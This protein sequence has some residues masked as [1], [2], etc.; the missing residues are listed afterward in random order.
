MRLTRLPYNLPARLSAQQSARISNLRRELVRAQGDDGSWTCPSALETLVTTCQAVLALCVLGDARDEERVNRAVR[1]LARPEVMNQE[2]AYWSAAVFNCVD[3]W[4]EE[5]DETFRRCEE[6]AVVGLKHHKDS[7]LFE[8]VCEQAKLLGKPS[9]FLDAHLGTIVSEIDEAEKRSQLNA[10]V[11]SYKYLVLCMAGGGS[12]D[13]TSAVLASLLARAFVTELEASWPG[14]IAS[15]AYVHM[16]LVAIR[17]A[18]SDSRLDEVIDKSYAA[19]ISRVDAKLFEHQL[20]AG[21]EFKKPSYSQA[22]ALR[23]ISHYE[24]YQRDGR[25]I[26]VT[27]FD[28]A[29]SR[30][31][32]YWVAGAVSMVAAFG[33]FVGPFLVGVLRANDLLSLQGAWTII[34]KMAVVWGLFG[35]SMFGLWQLLRKWTRGR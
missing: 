18:T 13:R 24:I 1:W 25:K 34:E 35:V 5:T 2:Y 8:F 15:T 19:I 30:R 32:L 21:G 4:D 23:A 6:L 16:N 26:G 3:G 7:P 12:P 14:N 27:A 29:K 28:R 11:L 9:S 17:E 10:H 22:V 31:M 20:P 33:V